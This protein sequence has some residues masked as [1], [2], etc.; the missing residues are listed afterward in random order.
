MPCTT[1]SLILDAAR[2]MGALPRPVSLDKTP[3][4][5]PK[6]ITVPSKPPLT[7]LAL[8]AFLNTKLATMNDLGGRF[9]KMSPCPNSAKKGTGAP[10]GE[11]LLCTDV[12]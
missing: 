7:A 1:G 4:A 11:L 5:T 2:A 6:R 10:Q 12:G 3:R 9:G 8:N